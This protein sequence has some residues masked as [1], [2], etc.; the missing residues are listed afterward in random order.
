MFKKQTLH[1]SIS[2]RCTSTC[3]LKYVLEG[4]V[5]W[6]IWGSLAL[7]CITLKGKEIEWNLPLFVLS[8]LPEQ[9]GFLYFRSPAHQGSLLYTT[10]LRKLREMRERWGGWNHLTREGIFKLLRSSGIDSKESIPPVYVTWR[11]GTTTLFLLGSWPP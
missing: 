1:I 9:R 3:I 7:L 10:G 2:S 11:A 4:T 6:D 8:A 5:P